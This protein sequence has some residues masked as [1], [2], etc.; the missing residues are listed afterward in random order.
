MEKFIYVFI[1]VLILLALPYFYQ[2]YKLKIISINDIPDSGS[3]VEV[4]RGNIYMSGLFRMQI[5]KLKGPWY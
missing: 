2:I 5:K 1:L 3:W 4:S